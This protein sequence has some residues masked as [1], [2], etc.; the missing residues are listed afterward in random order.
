[1]VRALRSKDLES[2]MEIWRNTNIQ[3]HS[4]ITEDYWNNNYNLVKEIL[5]QAEVYIYETKGRIQGFIG[6][7]SGYIAGL[8]VLQEEQSKG[9]GQALV[10]VVKE[11]YNQLSLKVYEK[12]I[13]AISF[14]E[15]QGFNKQSKAIDESTGEVEIFMVWEK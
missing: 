7:N 8:F 15:K 6:I 3:A 4:F 12:N 10:E 14:Y 13:K 5:P 2:V 1:M 11:Q 9:V